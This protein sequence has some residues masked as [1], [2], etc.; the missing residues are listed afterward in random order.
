MFASSNTGAKYESRANCKIK[1]HNATAIAT[2]TIISELAKSLVSI[3]TAD[4][5]LI[6]HLSSV[7]SL[8]C[9]IVF[10][11]VSSD[12]P[13]LNVTNIGVAPSL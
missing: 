7:I 1:K 9:S 4:I 3:T 6:L 12:I 5:P 13:S 2:Y 11:V 8:K 10:N